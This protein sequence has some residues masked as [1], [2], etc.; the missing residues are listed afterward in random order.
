MAAK[1]PELLLGPRGGPDQAL[2]RPRP[3]QGV[4]R[5]PEAK[6]QVRAPAGG[7]HPWHRPG[8]RGEAKAGPLPVAGRVQTRAGRAASEWTKAAASRISLSRATNRPKPTKR[9]TPG[10]V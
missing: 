1:P 8:G 9:S 4:G 2:R 10:R 3:G 6:I 7:A 5:I